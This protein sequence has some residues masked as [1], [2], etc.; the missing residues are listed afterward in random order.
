MTGH[1]LKIIYKNPWHFWIRLSKLTYHELNTRNNW[2]HIGSWHH[3]MGPLSALLALYKVKP[4]IT[5]GFPSQRTSNAALE[6][7]LLAWICCWIKGR[8]VGELRHITFMWCHCD[9]HWCIILFT[10]IAVLANAGPLIVW[11]VYRQ[12]TDRQFPQILFQNITRIPVYSLKYILLHRKYISLTHPVMISSY[13]YKASVCCLTT[14]DIVHSYIYCWCYNND[15]RYTLHWHHTG[16]M[17]SQ[18]TGNST[19]CQ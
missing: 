16:V 17:K 15:N 9:A 1:H 6:C 10:I 19:L 18:I 11:V 5:A 2:P 3:G 4:S 8:V 14:R 7:L 12:Q 13:V